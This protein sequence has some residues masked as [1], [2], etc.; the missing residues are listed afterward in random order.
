V[1]NGH[2][3]VAARE[4]TVLVLLGFAVDRIVVVAGTRLRTGPSPHRRSFDRCNCRRASGMHHRMLS[5]GM[6]SRQSDESRHDFRHARATRGRAPIRS[7]RG[8]RRWFRASCYL[9]AAG[10]EVR[11]QGSVQGFL[12]TPS[13]Y[14]L[15]GCTCRRAGSDNVEPRVLNHDRRFAR[16]RRVAVD[17]RRPRV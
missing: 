2:P 13:L 9:T 3:Q 14:R 15:E 17:A 5:A 11:G 1:L 8:R 7:L 4:A 6:V 16:R 12:T 10:S